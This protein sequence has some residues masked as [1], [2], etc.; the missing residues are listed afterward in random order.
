[1]VDRGG[2]GA[3]AA[4]PIDPAAR[5]RRAEAGPAYASC[6]GVVVAVGAVE[7]GELVPRRVFN[8]PF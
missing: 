7:H 2:R 5:P 3:P 4:R 6:G 8:L 1:M